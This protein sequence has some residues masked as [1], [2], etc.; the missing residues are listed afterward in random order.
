[1]VWC[2]SKPRVFFTNADMGEHSLQDTS[3]EKIHAKVL[4]LEE[5]ADLVHIRKA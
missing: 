3:Q 1:M 4:S 2:H 5:D